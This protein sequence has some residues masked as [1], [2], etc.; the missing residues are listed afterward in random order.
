MGGTEATAGPES[1]QIACSMASVLLKHVRAT[2]GDS[3]VDELLV[4][5]GV[6]Y[7]VAFLDDTGNWIWH[8]EAV[9][10]FETAAEL[11]GDR[12]IGVS[13]GELMVRQHAGTQVATLFRS[14]G[15]PEAVFE[16]LALVVTKFSTI[17]EM[18]PLEVGPGRAIVRSKARHGFGRHPHMCNLS[19][20]TLSQPPALFGLPSAHVEE[21]ECEARGDD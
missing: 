15:S 20:G 8:Q 10:L 17:T 3:A 9:A 12:N 4:R 2:L 1:G 5:S 16:Q 6:P 13:V 21:S 19:R 18:T 11:T 14:L 7:T